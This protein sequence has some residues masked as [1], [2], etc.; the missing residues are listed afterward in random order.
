[1][2]TH[3][4]RRKFIE[5]LRSCNGLGY[6]QY[7]FPIA[8]LYLFGDD[9][10]LRF[11]FFGCALMDG[12]DLAAQFVEARTRS[13]DRAVRFLDAYLEKKPG[14]L[15]S[16]DLSRYTE[17]QRKVYRALSETKFGVVTSYNELAVRA[18]MPGAARFVGSCMADNIFPVFIPCHRVLPSSGGIGDYSGGIEIKRF[19]LQHE[20]VL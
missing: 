3:L 11:A 5:Y 4:H 16:L 14:M 8:S 18:A 1:M 12:R 17:K 19:L 9:T 20:G 2:R 13:I 7:P 10:T 6:Y 15:P